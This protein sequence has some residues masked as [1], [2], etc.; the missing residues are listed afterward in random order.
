M[1]KKTIITFLILTGLTYISTLEARKLYY[2][3]TGISNIAKNYLGV[4]YKFGGSSPD[5]F[6]CSGYTGYVYKK[7]GYRLPR[8]AK[9]QYKKMYPIRV[10][11]PGDL[12]F[13][14]TSGS[15]ISHVGIYV[16]DYQFVHA[17]S[18]GKKVSFADIRIKYWKKRYAGARSIFRDD[19]E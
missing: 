6:D 2:D 3:G 9:D 19:T 8:G 5:G 14:K 12:V 18:T 4:P 17:P 10:P 1:K 15:R 11:K 16:G 13:F 7:S